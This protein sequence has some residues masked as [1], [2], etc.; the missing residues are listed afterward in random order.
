MNVDMHIIAGTTYCPDCGHYHPIIQAEDGHRFTM[1]DY[2]TAESW[3]DVS[4]LPALSQREAYRRIES[5]M[6]SRDD[7]WRKLRAYWRGRVV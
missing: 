7:V 2:Q 5:E 3:P 1:C 6:H 4:D